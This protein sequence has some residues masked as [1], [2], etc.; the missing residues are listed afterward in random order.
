MKQ[1]FRNF[2]SVEDAYKILED[3]DSPPHLIQHVKLVAQA[4]EILILQFQQ[5]NISFDPEWIRLGVAFH[6]TG[7]ILYPVELTER[8]DRHEAAGEQLLLNRGI[9][10]KIAR[11][12]RSHGQWNQMECSFE[13]LAVALA[14]CLWKG[15]RNVELEHLTISRAAQM[16][17]QDYWDVFVKLDDLFEEIA[18]NG[19]LRLSISLLPKYN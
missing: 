1:Q 17:N 10:P 2:D 14:D 7:K 19:D 6:D 9:D 8:G 11:C 4:A 12:C 16:L 18:R 13:E 15:K 5:L 3:L